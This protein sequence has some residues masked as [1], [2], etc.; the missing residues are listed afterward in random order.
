MAGLLAKFRIDYSDLK[1][2]PDYN[3]K[4]QES[5]RAFFESLIAPFRNKE[6]GYE[7]QDGKWNEYGLYSRFMRSNINYLRSQLLYYFVKVH[8]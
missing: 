3:K 4:P 8:L 5:T 1:L 2:I 6:D 7:E